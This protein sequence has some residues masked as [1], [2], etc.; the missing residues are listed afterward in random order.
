MGKKKKQETT[1]TNNSKITYHGNV[2]VSITTNGVVTKSFK[3]NN[4]GTL[5][6]FQQMALSLIQFQNHLTP[7]FI[8]VGTSNETNDDITLNKLKSEISNS[9]VPLVNKKVEVLQDGNNNTIGYKAQFTGTE[10]YSIVGRTT[11]KEIGLYGDVSGN[12]LLARIV[13]DN[14]I[15]LSQ[16]QS[17][18]IDWTM[19]ISNK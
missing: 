11:I 3:V 9:R 4:N 19:G 13:I 14:G 10:Y 7:N 1:V 5:L 6:L 2:K 16:N 18:I 17:L 15:S 8:A 12:S